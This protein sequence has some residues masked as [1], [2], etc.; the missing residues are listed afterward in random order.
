M[1]GH[2]GHG[3]GGLGKQLPRAVEPVSPELSGWRALEV[4]EEAPFERPSRNAGAL[5]HVAHMHGQICLLA[6]VGQRSPLDGRRW[7]YANDRS[8]ALPEGCG[9]EAAIRAVWAA[10]SNKR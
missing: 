4:F 8:P 3:K 5:G 1:L 7:Y 2:L 9:D 10:D 6:D